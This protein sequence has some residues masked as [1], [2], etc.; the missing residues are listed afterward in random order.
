MNNAPR[1]HSRRSVRNDRRTNSNL[2]MM[3]IDDESVWLESGPLPLNISEAK[4]QK[5][6]QEEYTDHVVNFALEL[7]IQT[8]VDIIYKKYLEETSYKFV[9]HCSH[10][11]LQ[12]L[13]NWMYLNYDP[14]ETSATIAEFWSGDKEQET[15]PKDAWACRSVPLQRKEPSPPVSSDQHKICE[16]KCS[17]EVILEFPVLENIELPS[18]EPAETPSFIVESLPRKRSTG[19]HFDIFENKMASQSSINEAEEL[20][21]F[22]RTMMM[23]K[24]ELP[25]PSWSLKQPTRSNICRRKNS[26]WPMEVSAPLNISNFEHLVPERY[27]Y[28]IPS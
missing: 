28:P 24:D 4:W 1:R 12:Q 7:I 20:S 23:P 8:A 22:S 16:E 13:F 15:L 14:G 27:P 2:R 17:D 6:Q 19:D 11:A 26:R 5:I 3:E 9:V 21:T 25:M 18:S 10:Q